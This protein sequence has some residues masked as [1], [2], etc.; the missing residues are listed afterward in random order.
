MKNAVVESLLVGSDEAAAMCGISRTA[1]WGLHS[2][3]RVPAPIRLGR[4]TLWSVDELRGWIKA[5]C[6]AREKWLM[7]QAAS[8]IPLPTK[9][10]RG[11]ST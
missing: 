4:R 10:R 11:K 2:Q 1:W 3:S 6:P 7:Q 5:G 9:N 8:G